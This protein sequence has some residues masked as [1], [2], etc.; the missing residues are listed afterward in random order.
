MDG[1]NGWAVSRA[2]EVVGATNAGLEV[3]AEDLP[4]P[5]FRA[6]LALK[7]AQG[8]FEEEMRKEAQRKNGT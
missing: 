8:E 3:K 2:V 1:P 7:A 5:V 4:Y 6:V